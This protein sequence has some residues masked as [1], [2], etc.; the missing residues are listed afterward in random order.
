VG[1]TVISEVLIRNN[2][3]LRTLKDIGTFYQ[4][5]T[6][7][8]P[9]KTLKPEQREQLMELFKDYNAKAFDRIMQFNIMQIQGPT[10][11]PDLLEGEQALQFKKH[12]VTGHYIPQARWKTQTPW[13]VA[14]TDERLIQ[15][16][17][18]KQEAD[19]MLRQEMQKEA[20]RLKSSSNRIKN[21]EAY[22]QTHW[23][24]N[25]ATEHARQNLEQKLNALLSEGVV[26]T[27]TKDKAYDIILKNNYVK[28]VR[29]LTA[30]EILN[31]RLYI[32]DIEKPLFN[33]PEE[34]VS[35][36]ATILLDKGKPVKK[37]IRTLRN[38]GTK[39][40]NDWDIELYKSESEM[41]DAIR[42]EITAPINGK[43]VD[44]IAAYNAPYDI[45]H[46]EEAGDFEIGERESDP[47]VEVAVDFFR[48]LKVHGKL[49][50]DPLRQ[51]RV[52][53]RHLPNRKFELVLAEA[54]NILSSKLVNYEQLALL[55]RTSKYNDTSILTPHLKD[56]VTKEAGTIT[57]ENCALTAAKYVAGDVDHLQQ[58]LQSQWYKDHLADCVKISETYHVELSRIMHSVK[59]INDAQERCYFDFVGTYRDVVYKK[60][61]KMIRLQQEGRSYLMDRLAYHLCQQSRAGAHK[62]VYKVSLPVGM[63]LAEHVAGINP[64]NPQQRFTDVLKLRDYALQFRNDK[65]R[66]AAI[67]QYLDSLADYLMID[68]GLL[69]KAKSEFNTKLAEAGIEYRAFEEAYKEIKTGLN[70]LPQFLGKIPPAEFWQQYR[71]FKAKLQ[72][73]SEWGPT[74]L[75]KGTLTAKGVLK[76]ADEQLKSFWQKYNINAEQFTEMLRAAREE[77]QAIHSARELP[78]TTLETHLGPKA[79][80]LMA[81]FETSTST[82]NELVHL[83]SRI[84]KRERKMFGQYNVKAFAVKK[85]LLDRIS[86]V[87]K[88]ANN[89]SYRSIHAQ[90]GFIYLQG[91]DPNPL[92]SPDAPVILA[93]TI[94]AAYVSINPSD[95][96]PRKFSQELKHKIFYPKH[97]YYEGIKVTDRPSNLMTMLEMRCY[98][99]LVELVMKQDFEGALE[100]ANS[101]L[102]ELRNILK[103]KEEDAAAWKNIVVD[104]KLVDRE[105]YDPF[106]TI[107]KEDLVWHSKKNDRY[108]AYE[109]GQLIHFV[110]DEKRAT[111]EIHEGRRRYFEEPVR[112]GSERTRTVYIM[113]ISDLHPDVE[114]MY[115]RMQDR[116]RDFIEPITGHWDAAKFVKKPQKKVASYIKMTDIFA[117]FQK[118]HR[119]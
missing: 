56:L 51:A 37:T 39:R 90:A 7:N 79:R 14:E 78:E 13:T 82:M 112:K 22:V 4:E 87:H 47:K 8:F 101:A 113:Q 80:K 65:P 25:E 27:N 66:Y 68:F 84:E 85:T 42:T 105:T 110:T 103:A 63:W 98:A 93:D 9:S 29:S 1:E 95:P 49:V 36:V 48:K 15:I 55:E 96:R 24:G 59:T 75:R 100:H 67:N 119:V 43:T 30:E 38:P 23:K 72:K 28:P 64:N 97:N 106:L 53:F 61:K 16:L 11:L 73:E 70:P 104:E 20:E 71:L 92:S 74:H 57:P 32:I 115:K 35:W 52:R 99:P 12:F 118:D 5:W 107:K 26:E 94:P 34:E 91:T 69:E 102:D 6:H 60:F 21:H 46:T 114:M 86:E 2:R 111:G 76:H 50:L 44:A 89:N 19:E 108:K 40:L 18:E 10:N 81:D 3:L 45:E 62:N 88:F 17:K 54:Q 31:S 109:H 58:M 116:I 117:L 83:R 41:V 33:T 77:H